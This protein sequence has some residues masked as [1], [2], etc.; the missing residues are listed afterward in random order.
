MSSSNTLLPKSFDG[1]SEN[2]DSFFVQFEITCK[3]SPCP[4]N[5][6]VYWLV[7]C[8]QGPALLYV[9]GLLQ[10]MPVESDVLKQALV[11]LLC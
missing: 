11:H 3:I 2:L 9:N 4:E 1:S 8:L 7:K 6:K 10:Y 5:Q